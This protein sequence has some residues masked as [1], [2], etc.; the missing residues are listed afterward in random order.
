MKED[1]LI[2]ILLNLVL[3][4]KQAEKNQPNLPKTKHLQKY[5]L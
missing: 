2:N 1:S 5:N 3:I 4:L